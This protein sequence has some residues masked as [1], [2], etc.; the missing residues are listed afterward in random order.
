MS[1]WNAALDQGKLTKEIVEHLFD[2]HNDEEI[3][4]LLLRRNNTTQK[5]GRII[6]AV[7]NAVKLKYQPQNPGAFAQ[8]KREIQSRFEA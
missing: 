1:Y 2:N 6:Q 3:A 4:E 5:Q 8:G 7:Q